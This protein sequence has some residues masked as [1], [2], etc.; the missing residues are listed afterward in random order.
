MFGMEGQSGHVIYYPA[1]QGFSP[2]EVSSI[3]QIIRDFSILLYSPQSLRKSSKVDYYH[4]QDGDL[5]SCV[6]ESAML[7]LLSIT[8]LT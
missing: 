5:S 7:R 2:F 8:A 4:R 1:T 6:C 3:K